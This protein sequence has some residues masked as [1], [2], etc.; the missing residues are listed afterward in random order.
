MPPISLKKV[1]IAIL[2]IIVLSRLDRISAF[3]SAV[4]YFFY[5]SFKGFHCPARGRLALATLILALIYITI[6]KLLHEKIN[7]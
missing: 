1:A 7:K 3:A 6:Y 4:Y 5:D 2:L